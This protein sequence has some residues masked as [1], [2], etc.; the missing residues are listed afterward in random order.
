MGKEIILSTIR[1]NR[2]PEAT[3]PEIPDFFPD[4]GE[5]LE[6]FIEAVELAAGK[7]FKIAHP[8]NI[9]DVL[10]EHFPGALNI[11][12]TVNTIASNVDL[13]RIR[14]PGDLESVDVAVIPARLGV[15]ENGA[16]WVND[17]DLVHRVLPFITQHLVL[18]LSRERI[19]WNMHE[20]YRNIA[21]L[22][23]GFGVFIAG[24]SKTADIEQALVIGAQGAR[25]FSVILI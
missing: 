2:P 21:S 4:A 16:V 23:G 6:M 18:V 19:C 25:S 1:Q 24:P 13:G 14:N 12:S 8:E 10:K 9:N 22:L 17:E 20:A 15:A 11:A 5:K 7:V 3:L